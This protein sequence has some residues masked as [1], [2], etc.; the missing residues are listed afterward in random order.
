VGGIYSTHGDDN[1][2][3]SLA[4]GGKRQ[5]PL[6]IHM[7]RREDNTEIDIERIKCMLSV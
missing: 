1:V 4:R 7:Y 3:K 6:W 2:D 5:R